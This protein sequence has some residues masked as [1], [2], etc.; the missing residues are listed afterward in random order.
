MGVLMR[1][2]ADLYRLP[3]LRY[4]VVWLLGWTPHSASQGSFSICVCL[5]FF[6]PKCTHH[7]HNPPPMM[8]R[9]QAAVLFAKLLRVTVGRQQLATRACVPVAGVVR[10]TLVFF[11][12]EGGRFCARVFF[13]CFESRRHLV[14]H[15]VILP[16]DCW[17][18]RYHQLSYV[19][20]VWSMPCCRCRWCSVAVVGC[21]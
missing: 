8:P 14:C 16:S 5:H 13:I 18:Y 11:D 17:S 15:I 9:E 12:G 3:W 6:L 7:N 4:L 20:I 1:A 10:A 19:G 2:G 21:V